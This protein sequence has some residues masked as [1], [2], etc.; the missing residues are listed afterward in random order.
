MVALAGVAGILG[1]WFLTT[2]REKSLLQ[3]IGEWAGGPA[4]D[5]EW[6]LVHEP[7]PPNVYAHTSPDGTVWTVVEEAVPPSESVMRALT[8]E[9]KDYGQAAILDNSVGIERPTEL[10][11]EA[12]LDPRIY[13]VDT[14]KPAGEGTIVSKAAASYPRGEPHPDRRYRI[15]PRVYRV[16]VTDG[17]KLRL[18][19]R[20]PQGDI[21]YVAYEAS[22]PRAP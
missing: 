9:S 19:Y 4:R 11:P 12:K 5:S 14:I 3:P 17:K 13:V 1:I 7:P 22:R 20:I 8:V 10:C 21:P 15:E 6:R 2:G 16:V 18:G